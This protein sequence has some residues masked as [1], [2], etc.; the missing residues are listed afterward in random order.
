VNVRTFERSNGRGW[1]LD[2]SGLVWAAAAAFLVVLVIVPLVY[3]L[4]FSLGFPRAL[5]FRYYASAFT[6]PKL[7]GPIRDTLVLGGTV[8]LL[9][10]VLGAPLAW[11]VT[12][13]DMPGRGLVRTLAI[14]SFVTPPFLGAMAW[15]IL[16]GP[17]AGLL[18]QAYRALTGATEPLFNIFSLPGLIVVMS[19][20]TYPF[21]FIITANALAAISPELE[22]AASIAG[23]SPWHAGLGITLPLAL[24]AILGGFILAVLEAIVLFGSPAMIAI[25]ARFHV[26]TTQL[27]ALFHYPPKLELA[28]A[29]SLPL[30]VVAIAL[31]WLQRR[32]LGRK[33]FATLTGKATQVRIQRL[34]RW[35]YLLLAYCFF[36]LLLSV[37]LPYWTLAS[38]ALSKAWGRGLSLDNL[39]LAN[40]RHLL[41][42][43][44][45]TRDAIAN[46][47]KI[48]LVTATVGA[49]VSA[50][51]A[52]VSERRLV[53][54]HR[55]LAF[56]ATA[57]IAIPG[58]VLSVGLFAAYTRPPLILYGTIWILFV[59]YLTK[60]LPI[61][62]T[63]N[64]AAVT[65]VHV[66]LEDAARILGA[67]RLRAFADVTVPLF[68]TGLAAAFL[69]VFLPSLRELSSSILLFTARSRVVAVVIYELYEEG[70]WEAVSAMG[71]LLLGITLLIVGLAYH[72]LGRRFLSL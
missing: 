51:V 34:G 68:K 33:G 54:G 57:P 22:D 55:G 39:T 18:N 62:Y 23:A 65:S 56:L 6:D 16:A 8:G 64:R 60:Y 44:Q 72:F 3:L 9:S 12:R 24:P 48:A 29:Y 15:I 30:L 69:L 28:A 53:R 58:I 38:A 2:A 63:A 47:L 17:N 70:L 37:G 20:Y 40:F 66:E 36:I 11:A 50:L 32:M 1:R 27:W 25:P 7:L 14:A 35:R 19:L 10:V 5:T 71:I 31:L 13:T 49:V 67:S 45:P 61:A 41:F 42:E 21:V 43:H 59:S 46:T 4:A 52:Y 26:M